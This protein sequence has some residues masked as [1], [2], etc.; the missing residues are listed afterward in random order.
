[1]ENTELLIIVGG[2]IA[3]MWGAFTAFVLVAR[4]NDRTLHAFQAALQPA[5]DALTGQADRTLAAYGERLAPLNA[6]LTLL[7]TQLD[8]PEDWLTQ[9]IGNESVV[10]ALR[11]ALA[12]VQDLTDGEI[13]TLKPNAS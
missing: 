2:L 7:A 13:D 10:A 12:Q 6:A 11:A 4:A 3:V 5:M 8:D 9:A 1:M